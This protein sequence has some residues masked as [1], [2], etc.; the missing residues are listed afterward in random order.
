MIRIGPGIPI[1]RIFDEPLA[2]DFYLGY[3]GFKVDWEHRFEPGMPLYMQV[4]RDELQLHLS[5][6]VGDASPGARLYIPMQGAEDFHTELSARTW[7]LLRP[8]IEERP[9]GRELGLID[10]FN[11]RLTFCEEFSSELES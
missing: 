11:N 1:L 3:A 10:P 5:E 4:S 6:H 9:W 2:R 8:G 7:R